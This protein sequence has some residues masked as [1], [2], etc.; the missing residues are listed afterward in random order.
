MF[1]YLPLFVFSS[2]FSLLLFQYHSAIEAPCSCAFFSVLSSVIFQECDTP[3]C[4][5][6]HCL[7]NEPFTVCVWIS[8]LFMICNPIQCHSMPM[9]CHL[10]FFE[11]I[12][13]TQ[14]LWQFL[15]ITRLKPHC[16]LATQLTDNTII[17]KK[18][19]GMSRY[20]FTDTRWSEVVGGNFKIHLF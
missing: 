20:Y 19:S 11:K 2:V 3:F 12:N 7:L 16:F 1:R 5:L 8:F 15:A 17:I 4:G 14:Q 9:Q 6:R 18:C 13:V 10:T